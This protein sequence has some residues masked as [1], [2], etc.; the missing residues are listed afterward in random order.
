M[1]LEGKEAPAHTW[2]GAQFPAS[3]YEQERPWNGTHE[4][5]WVHGHGARGGARGRYHPYAHPLQTQ[6]PTAH[7]CQMSD[8]A[9]GVYSYHQVSHVLHQYCAP[10]LHPGQ[11]QLQGTGQPP[12]Q[13]C[14]KHPSYQYELPACNYHGCDA[15]AT[16]ETGVQPERKLSL[17]S[18]SGSRAEGGGRKEPIW[19][20]ADCKPRHSKGQGNPSGAHFAD[21][22]CPT[23]YDDLEPQVPWASSLSPE[24][25][26]AEVERRRALPILL[27]DLN[28][29]GLEH[30]AG[31]LAAY[32]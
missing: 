29:A 22:A 10:G 23:K 7:Q 11:P 30:G 24:E 28:G 3:G 26:M 2:G 27:F 9:Y 5:G 17:G 25:R 18:G 4:S 14:Y 1:D 19:A 6:P 31:H 20:L 8:A 12:Y 16:Q 15:F 21:P 32:T 13:S